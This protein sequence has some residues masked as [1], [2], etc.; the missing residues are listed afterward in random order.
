VRSHP[1]TIVLLCA[2]VLLA[3][4]SAQ[5]QRAPA[6]TPL[7]LIPAGNDRGLWLVRAEDDPSHFSVAVRPTGGK[8]DWVARGLTGQVAAATVAGD[9]LHVFFVTGGYRLF[10]P[11]GVD[12]PGPMLPAPA[13]GVCPAG[14]ISGRSEVLAVTARSASATSVSV[15]DSTDPPTSRPA[16]GLT[17][18]VDL[19]V[20]QDQPDGWRK[21]TTLQGIRLS[22]ESR[23]R[24]AAVGETVFLLVVAAPGG[25]NDLYAWSGDA[26]RRAPLPEKAQSAAVW[27]MTNLDG[28]LLIGLA[29]SVDSGDEA[30]LLL[31]RRLSDADEFTLQP[32]GSQGDPRT[33]AIRSLPVATPFGGEGQIALVWR[34]EGT[35]HLGF[36]SPSGEFSPQADVDV[37]KRPPTDGRGDRLHEKFLWG[38]TLAIFV[39]MFALRPR[40][41]PTPF[42]LPEGVL[43]G[44]LPKRIVAAL[45]D[46]GP[47][48]LLVPVIFYPEIFAQT[49]PSEG[50]IDPLEH[51]RR[52]ANEH[53][54]AVTYSSLASLCLYT[55]YATLMEWRW[56][57]TL[58]KRLMQL[59]VVGNGGEPADGR[60]V[61][62]RNLARLIPLSSTV[63]MPL[64]I[65]FP[66][67]NINRQ[68]LGDMLA[69]T[70]V[71]DARS[72]PVQEDTEPA[73]PSESID[74]GEPGD[75]G[76]D[77]PPPPTE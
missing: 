47:F 71:I 30:R 74:E 14:R 49:M 64:L 54:D 70:T 56:G 50:T 42:V 15:D 40:T 6:P 75:P 24:I 16:I 72:K 26:W 22:Q 3:C 76:E 63:L 17:N 58:G 9:R 44:S 31:A 2:M 77:S 52:I 23:I 29:E 48:L 65:V 5:A 1:I 66:L 39:L 20:L 21:L 12:S 19:D 59:C 73:E 53:P 45:I 62:L 32:V 10:S 7:Q 33:W 43:P 55:V 60:Q 27:A 37:F 4:S 36:C 61:I 28:K 34:T 8:W 69:R 67:L 46:A 35:I 38:L 57:Q 13:L 51:V 68:R 18:L 41:P 11:G 25:Q